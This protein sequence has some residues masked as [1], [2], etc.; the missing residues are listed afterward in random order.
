V[1]PP[2]GPKKRRTALDAH[3]A[4][5]SRI[6]R[7]NRCKA[8][9]QQRE[10]HIQAWK[11]Q[12]FTNFTHKLHLSILQSSDVTTFWK[13]A[14]TACTLKQQ[15]KQQQQ[16]QQQEEEEASSTANYGENST[17]QGAVNAGVRSSTQR[18]CR[19]TKTGPAFYLSSCRG[20]DSGPGNHYHNDPLFHVHAQYPASELAYSCKPDTEIA[21]KAQILTLIST[22]HKKSPSAFLKGPRKRGLELQ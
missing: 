13:P 9:Q 21:A 2:S 19:D 14:A 8:E 5:L 18:N 3:K 11:Q 22:K 16:Q 4:T 17:L 6:Q 15:Q 12:Q 20:Q 1:R 10:Q 7:S